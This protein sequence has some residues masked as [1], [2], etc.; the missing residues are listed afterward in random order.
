MFVG[1]PGASGQADASGEEG[2]A[3]AVDVGG[4][5]AIDGLPVHGFPQ[6]AA[7][8]VCGVEGHAKGFHVVVGLA[9]GDGTAGSVCDACRTAYGAGD[10]LS[11]G[12]FFILNL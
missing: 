12:Q 3:D 1:D 9:V 8:Y 7:L 11:V 5:V 2:L 4:A 6:G 10:D